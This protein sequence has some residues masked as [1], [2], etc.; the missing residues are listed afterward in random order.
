MVCIDMPSDFALI[1][2]RCYFSSRRVEEVVGKRVFNMDVEN[3]L[4]SSI[5]IV[6]IN[7]SKGLGSGAAVTLTETVTVTDGMVSIAATTGTA[8]IPMLSAIEIVTYVP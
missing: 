8:G 3:T 6:Q 1:L 4:L 5:D 7:A 2:H